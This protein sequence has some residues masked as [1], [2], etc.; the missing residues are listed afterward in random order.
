MIWNRTLSVIP[1]RAEGRFAA[2]RNDERESR[3]QTFEI[4]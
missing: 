2:A 3:R 1:G 4:K